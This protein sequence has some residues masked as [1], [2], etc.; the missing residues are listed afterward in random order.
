MPPPDAAEP[1]S[2][3]RPRDP[4]RDT[5]L[6]AAVSEILPEVGYDRLTMDSV[7]VRAGASRATVYRRWKDKSELVRDAV[8]LLA[9]TE[10]VPDTGSLRSDLLAVG[11]MYL[12]RD[13]PR[14]AILSAI[15][16][17]IKRDPRLRD[18]VDEVIAAPR[19]AAYAA[20]VDNAR[21][22]GEIAATAD[23]ALIA[24]VVPAMIF[25]RLLDSEEPL[26]GDYYERV[27]DSLIVPLLTG[28]AADSGAA[29]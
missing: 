8:R 5:A 24:D 26:D 20:I 7:A 15:A 9:W 27:V 18:T 19:R 22:R 13:G 2:H 12:D 21:A 29:H 10:P 11:A 17:S 28:K 6:L 3:G 4:E 23:T 1:K 14:D 25:Y 16:A